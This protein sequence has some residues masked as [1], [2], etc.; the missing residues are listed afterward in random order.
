MVPSLPARVLGTDVLPAQLL[1][2]D[3]ALITLTE[4]T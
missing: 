3:P 1:T 2:I 4:Q